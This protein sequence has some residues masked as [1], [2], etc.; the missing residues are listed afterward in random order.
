LKLIYKQLDRG[1]CCNENVIFL[2]NS[3]TRKECEEQDASDEED[4]LPLSKYRYA[5]E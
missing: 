2:T 5:P 3:N 1:N 4:N